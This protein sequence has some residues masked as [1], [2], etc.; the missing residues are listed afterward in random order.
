MRVLFERRPRTLHVYHAVGE[1][2]GRLAADEALVGYGSGWRRKFAETLGQSEST[3]TKCLQ[4]F[5]AYER[6]DIAALEELKVGWVGLI[7]ALGVRDKKER[8]RLLRRARD[9]GWGQR[10]LRREARRL[11]GSNRGGGRPRKEERSRGCLADAVELA[12]LAGLWSDFYRQ[13]W[14][15]TEGDYLAE[16]GRLT[17]DSRD[18][19]E[20]ALADAEEKLKALRGQCAG[21]LKAVKEL[22]EKLPPGG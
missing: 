15:G 19:M 11:K 9:E 18:G 10:E 13:A 1:Q 22:R 7:V 2:M 16:V 8:H 3:L 14:A 6:D 5:N 20:R 17:G 4:F 12:R 21:A